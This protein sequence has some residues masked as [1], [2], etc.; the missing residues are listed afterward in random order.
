LTAWRASRG[1]ARDRSGQRPLQHF[2]PGGHPCSPRAPHSAQ[3]LAAVTRL[4]KPRALNEKMMRMT[5]K[6]IA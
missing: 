5:P 6:A 2:P 1:D 4:A 3:A